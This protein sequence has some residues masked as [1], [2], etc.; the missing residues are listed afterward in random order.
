MC[1]NQMMYMML[2]DKMIAFRKK[3]YENGLEVAKQDDPIL[4][5]NH[6]NDELDQYEILDLIAEYL[7]ETKKEI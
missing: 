5:E 1:M 2:A 7:N 3:I 6:F 4:F